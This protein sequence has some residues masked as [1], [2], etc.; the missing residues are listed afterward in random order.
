MK[1]EAC[2]TGK[3]NLCGVPFGKKLVESFLEAYAKNEGNSR[4]I[5]GKGLCS[6]HRNL[7]MALRNIVI[8]VNQLRT[9]TLQQMAIVAEKEHI[10]IDPE[11][12]KLCKTRCHYDEI[13][14]IQELPEEETFEMTVENKHAYITNGLLC[15]NS[16]GMEYPLVIMPFIKAHGT[17]LLQRNL[18]YTAITRAKK[19]V[20]ILGQ[21]SAIEAAILNNKIQKRNTRFAER[22]REWAQGKGVSM[23]DMFSGSSGYQ[24]SAVLNRLLSLEESGG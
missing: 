23:R 5:K 22:I 4:G 13:I 9:P 15:H 17:M 14:E 24:N 10:C 2:V 1:Y 19:K 20:I 6:K 16:Q 18:L 11:I 8:G 12:T 3:T 7:Y 21:A